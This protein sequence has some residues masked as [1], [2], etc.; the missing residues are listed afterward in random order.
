MAPGPVSPQ[1]L[2]DNYVPNQGD[3]CTSAAVLNSLGALGAQH[4]PGLDQASAAISGVGSFQPPRLTDY[5]GIPFLRRAPIDSR[6]EKFA[7]S[8]G[9]KVRSTTRL[10]LIPSKLAPFASN[11]TMP[12]A[13]ETLI[14][15]MAYGQERPGV[16]GWWGFNLLKPTAWNRAGH[17][18][19]IAGAQGSGWAVVDSDN[20]G[21]QQWAR[22]GWAMANTRIQVLE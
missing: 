15:H 4:L 20:P 12:G 18:V 22:P 16:W 17:S 21:I 14:G 10:S 13:G 11:L 8:H 5:I 2:L 3:S 9:L 1:Q 19:I 6:I 7:A